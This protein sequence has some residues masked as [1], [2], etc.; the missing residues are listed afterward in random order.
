MMVAVV[1]IADPLDVGK[2]V[3]RIGVVATIPVSMMD[4]EMVVEGPKAEMV[5]S[6]IADVNTLV[7]V[8]KLDENTR[9]EIGVAVG[10]KVIVK[11]VGEEFE[12]RPTTRGLSINS[13]EYK[14]A[15]T[16]AELEEAIR[17]A[18][19][20]RMTM[21][22]FTRR[23]LEAENVTAPDGTILSKADA[24]AH[25][26]FDETEG[27]GHFPDEFTGYSEADVA[28]ITKE[29]IIATHDEVSKQGKE[30]CPTGERAVYWEAPIDDLAAYLKITRDAPEAI[31]ERVFAQIVGKQPFQDCNHRTA[32]AVGKM[33]MACFGRE[34]VADEGEKKMLG[35][36]YKG[37]IG[38]QEVIDWITA[39]SRVRLNSSEPSLS[40]TARSRAT[41]QRNSAANSSSFMGHQSGKLSSIQPSSLMA[42]ARA[43]SNVISGSS[44][45]VNAP[46]TIKYL[47][48]YGGSNEAY[49]GMRCKGCS[50]ADGYMQ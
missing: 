29:R 33:V 39:H 9:R 31:V 26:V 50:D 25:G 48:K 24:R 49:L 13:E 1:E 16:V 2:N 6:A 30:K 37:T 5:L 35:K 41:T 18:S 11:A 38:K 45:N 15:S 14:N 32:W 28:T 3:A 34:L 42:S 36:I 47:P 40:N 46:P 17:Q 19:K 43:S 10:A 22:D 27:I 21:A 12:A 7:G 4:D 20:P 8:V 44:M 23:I